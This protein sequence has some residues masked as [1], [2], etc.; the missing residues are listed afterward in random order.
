MRTYSV[1]NRPG[2][3]EVD[4]I[5]LICEQE[6]TVRFSKGYYLDAGTKLNDY[7]FQQLGMDPRQ[8]TLKVLGYDRGGSWP[9]A[10]TKE[11]LLKLV[12]FVLDK[13]EII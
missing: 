5:V 10:D 9:F 11:D 3:L 13:A 8:T 6:H 1:K 2:K 7:A 12:N 4:D